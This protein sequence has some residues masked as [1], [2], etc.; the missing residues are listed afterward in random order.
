[1]AELPETTRVVVIG[2]G[3]VGCSSLYHLAKRGWTDCL[4]LESNELTSGSSWHAAGNCPNFSGSWSIM[5]MQ[6]YSTELYGRLGDEADY[7]MNYHVT[8]SIRLA[9]NR[10]RMEEFRHVHAMAR[11]QGIDFEM[12]GPTRSRRAILSW[13]PHDLE[14]GIWDPGDGDI[15]PAQLTQA[16]AKAAR[17][18]GAKIV[19]F[20]P[21]TG[22]A[23]CG[24]RVGGRDAEGQGP[25]RGRGQRRRLPRREIGAMV[26]RQ[27]PTVAMSHQYLV[28]ESIES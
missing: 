13:R 22:C 9:H 25:L 4:L 2:G 18:L 21:A 17:N 24:R 27:V 3:A 5:K 14:G 12:L 11:Y 20:C 6:A 28:T 16:F 7:P 10:P 15:D 26:G 8:G 1:M 23:S 19:R